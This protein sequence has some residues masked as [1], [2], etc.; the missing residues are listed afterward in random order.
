MFPVDLR[1]PARR[2]NRLERQSRLRSSRRAQ[3]NR[4][5]DLEFTVVNH[6][7][8]KD[9]DQIKQEKYRYE[10]FLGKNVNYTTKSFQDFCND[11]FDVIPHAGGV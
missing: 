6:F 3:T 4:D 1:S 5:G 2:T 7:P 11:P 8:G 10:R 9:P